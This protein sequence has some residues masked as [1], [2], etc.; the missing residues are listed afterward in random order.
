MRWLSVDTVNFAILP[1]SF[2]CDHLRVDG[3][4]L[5]DCLSFG[6]VVF[7]GAQKLVGLFILF[8]FWGGGLGVSVGVM[9]NVLD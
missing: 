9:M 6:W 3:M 4:N 5:C 7:Y 2:F 1:K 8:Y